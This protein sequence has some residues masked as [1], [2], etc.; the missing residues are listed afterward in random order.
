MELYLN[1]KHV[2]RRTTAHLMHFPVDF[3]LLSTSEA[4]IRGTKTPTA[5]L[6]PSGIIWQRAFLFSPVRGS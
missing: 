5:H 2:A 6:E 1:R 3:L 4:G